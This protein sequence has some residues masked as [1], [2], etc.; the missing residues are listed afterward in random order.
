MR[1]GG[2]FNYK[3]LQT[4]GG[5]KRGYVANLLRMYGPSVAYVT[6]VLNLP[7]GTSGSSRES[8][9]SIRIRGSGR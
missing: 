8:I 1:R 7:R 4:G 3:K 5:D 2:G 6:T 9:R